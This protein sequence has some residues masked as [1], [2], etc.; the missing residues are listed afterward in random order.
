M[1]PGSDDKGRKMGMISENLRGLSQWFGRSAVMIVLGSGLAAF[2]DSTGTEAPAPAGK[3]GTESPDASSATEPSVNEVE[4][5]LLKQAHAV[6]ATSP[7]EALTLLTNSISAES[8]PALDFAAGV[9]ALMAEQPDRAVSDLRTALAK[10]PR[11]HRARANLA[12]VLLQQGRYD[13]AAAELRR[14][15]ES[16]VA[17]K[18]E[19]WRLLAFSLAAAGHP[20]AAETA[21]REACVWEPE[22]ETLR[23]ALIRS[24]L[25]QGDTERVAPMVRRELGKHPDNREFWSLLANIELARGQYPAALEILECA[26]RIGAA[27]A[28][29]LTTLGDLLLDAGLP[30]EAVEIYTRTAALKESSPARLLNALR[31]LVSLGRSEDAARLRQ[32]VSSDKIVLSETQRT[33][34]GVIDAELAQLAGDTGL[35]RK[36]YEE[37]LRVNPLEPTA[38]M[39]LA[40]ILRETGADAEADLLYERAANIPGLRVSALTARAQMA[41]AKGD[42]PGA[43]VLVQ[44]ALELGP[45]AQLEQYLASLRIVAAE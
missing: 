9:Y 23:L 17:G 24:I 44:K 33:E 14:L 8:S 19:Y 11:F 15:L 27:D 34:L 13:E 36:H 39:N 31:A 38:L 30:R 21:Y 2:A 45:N 18:G 25:D 29:M 37:V 22:D 40:E 32:A 35:A 41:V 10:M 6:S 16:D 26:R 42:L 20:E 43:I 28:A 1:E 7:T 12:K 4:A 5:E 3:P